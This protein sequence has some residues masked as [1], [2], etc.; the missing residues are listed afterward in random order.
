[1]NMK[2]I[3]CLAVAFAA[4]AIAGHFCP[5]KGT[6]AEDPSPATARPAVA[7]AP[8]GDLDAA[9]RRIRELERRVAALSAMPKA[10][11]PGKAT[12]D[13][14]VVSIDGMQ[15]NVFEMLQQKLPAEEFCQVTNAFERMKQARARRVHGKLAFLSSVDTSGMSDNER[16]THEEYMELV[17]EQEEL[18]GKAKGIIPDPATLEK[19]LSL[20][21]KTKPLADAERRLLLRQM[22]G[23]LGYS[24]D[25]ASVVIGTIEDI[26]GATSAGGLGAAMG[27][28]AEDFGGGLG[29]EGP[30]VEVKTQIVTP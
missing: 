11:M 26:V 25:D 20:Q 13:A 28:I 15:T 19:V 9:H 22:S 10:A 4:G 27:A 6:P 23:S 7:T 2:S 21:M 12:N 5:G 16:R 1:M 8:K 17:T 29:R 14:S 18:M 3:A 24:G 30:T